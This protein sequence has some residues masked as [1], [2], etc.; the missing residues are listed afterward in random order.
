MNNRRSHAGAMKSFTELHLI[1]NK[2]DC[3]FCGCHACLILSR[4]VWMM[5]SFTFMC[6]CIR[7]TER[8]LNDSRQA[9]GDQQNSEKPG[10]RERLRLYIQFLLIDILKIHS[11]LLKKPISQPRSCRY[12]DVWSTT[13]TTHCS[14]R[15]HTEHGC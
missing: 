10:H 1:D 11:G 6:C 7:K 9:G 8:G 2:A 15:I 13:V 3:I 14:S 5:V 12:R 4:I